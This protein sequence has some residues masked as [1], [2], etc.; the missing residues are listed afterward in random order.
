VR[1][2]EEGNGKPPPSE[3]QENSHESKDLKQLKIERDG[4]QLFRLSLGVGIDLTVQG[5]QVFEN[6]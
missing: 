4:D 6:L 2:P 3:C 5:D 1:N